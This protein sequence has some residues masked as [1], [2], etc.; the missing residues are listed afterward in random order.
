MNDVLE[1]KNY[2]AEVHFNSEDE[3]FH[4]KVIG[5]NDLVNF[6]GTT[7][8]ELKKA[9]H[10]AVNDYLA[11]CAELGKEPEKTYKGSFNV[12]ISPDLHRKA[13]KHAALK[14]MSLND[15]VRYAID[16]MVA[17]GPATPKQG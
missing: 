11:T 2:Y 10:E 1:Y 5:I 6:E 4:G 16:M 8:K 15:F 12:R 17:K 9:F 7:V 13:A 3:V 14:K